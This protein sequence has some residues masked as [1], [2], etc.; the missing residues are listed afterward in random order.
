MDECTCGAWGYTHACEQIQKEVLKKKKIVKG[1]TSYSL[2]SRSKKGRYREAS[3]VVCF[4]M[5]MKVTRLR[6]SKIANFATIRFFTAVD[7]LMLRKR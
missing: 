2:H 7:S 4:H 6:K 1:R 3:I 5:T